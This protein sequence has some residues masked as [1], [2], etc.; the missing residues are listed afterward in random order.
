M[1]KYVDQNGSVALLPPLP[2]SKRSAGVTPEVNLSNPLHADNEACKQGIHPGF[3][4]QGRCQ[5]KSKIGVSVVPQERL[6][7]SKN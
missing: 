3:E 2:L 1:C 4:A 7:S 5:N 6:M